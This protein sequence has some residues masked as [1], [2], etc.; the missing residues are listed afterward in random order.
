[1]GLSYRGPFARMGFGVWPNEED[2]IM[3]RERFERGLAT[4]KAVD[5]AAAAGIAGSLK[6]AYPELARL[7]IEF[8]YGDVMSRDGLDLRTRE[9]LSIAM[10]GALGNAPQQLDMHIRGALHTGATPHEII[11]TVL[12]IA[13]YAGFPAAFNVLNA[14]KRAF[15]ASPACRAPM[16]QALILP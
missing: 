11:E 6:G 8:G 3:V 5:P 14:P 13:A 16:T 12:Q 2:G 7:A 9:L 10:L 15:D 1:M 4:L